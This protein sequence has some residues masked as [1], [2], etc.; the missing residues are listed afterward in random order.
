MELLRPPI[1]Q[2]VLEAARLLAARGST[3]FTR[4]DLIAHVQVKNPTIDRASID[5]IIQGM[6]ENA[7]GG[8][9]SACGTVFRRVDRGRYSLVSEGSAAAYTPSPPRRMTSRSGVAPQVSAK[10][11]RV[12]ARVSA[13]IDGFDDLVAEYDENVP[14][15]REGQYEL[16]RATIDRRRLHPTVAE[17][18]GDEELLHLLHETLRRWGI[19]ARASVLASA[20]PFADALRAHANEL[21]MLDGLSLEH[22]G[23]TA[24]AVGEE[25]WRCLSTLPIVANVARVVPG[26]KA[27]HHLLPDLV[28]PMDRAWT[29][30]FFEWAPADLQGRQRPTFLNAWRDLA[31]VAASVKPSRLVGAGWRTSPTKVLDNAVVAYGMR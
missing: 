4:A 14:F 9:Q 21:V 18:L 1:W 11:R 20:E 2:L 5:P 22:L 29:G 24:E 28:P 27:L 26:T 17:A 7:P 23:D 8:V 16:H 6:T 19:G 15:R 13:L 3:I 31:R 30:R 25:V 12:D 10:R